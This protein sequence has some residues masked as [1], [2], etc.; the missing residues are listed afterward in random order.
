M[1]AWLSPAPLGRPVPRWLL[2]ALLLALAVGSV[3]VLRIGPPRWVVFLLVA[4]IGSVLIAPSHRLILL[5]PLIFLTGGGLVFDLIP[6]LWPVDEPMRVELAQRAG[7]VAVLWLLSTLGIAGIVAVALAALA[8]LSS[9]LILTMHPVGE[10]GRGAVMFHLLAMALGISGGCLVVENGEVKQKKDGALRLLGGPGLLVIRPCHAAVLERGGR[11]TGIMGP[12]VHQL[13]PFERVR[14]VIRLE[15]RLLMVDLRSVL[16]ADGLAVP[17][18]LAKVGYRF[19]PAGDQG[20]GDGRFTGTLRDD[21]YPTR[22]EDLRKMLEI[23]PD[24]AKWDKAVETIAVMA[25][26]AVIGRHTLEELFP[27]DREPVSAIGE[28]VSG[29]Y[30]LLSSEAQQECL[31]RTANWGIEIT[32]LRL[33]S[34]D[35]PEELRS[36]ALAPWVAER[37]KVLSL[38]QGE[39]DA[40]R[41]RAFEAIR[42]QARRKAVREFMDRLSE[43]YEGSKIPPEATHRL[44]SLIVNLVTCFAEDTAQ[45]MRLISALEKAVEGSQVLISVGLPPPVF[46]ASPG[47]PEREV[48]EPGVESHQ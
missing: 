29:P 25:I 31:T 47:R 45:G 35:L 33:D 32:M 37:E 17:R 19:P 2:G 38:A 18:V 48:T 3:A 4:I 10:L 15:P 20:E 28:E 40:K 21:L 6:L 26:R 27:L 16:T 36:R 12:H 43:L 46:P 39:A 44:A 9:E 8:L 34:M 23:E 1:N 7:S 41:E 14:G 5:I 22:R 30:D 24:P 13:R 42:L 11:I